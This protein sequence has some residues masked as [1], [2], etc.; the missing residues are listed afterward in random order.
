MAMAYGIAEVAMVTAGWWPWC[1][2]LVC[3]LVLAMLQESVPDLK[4]H[5][6]QSLNSVV[7]LI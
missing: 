1:A 6:L 3:S 2:L 4:L 5:V 7:H